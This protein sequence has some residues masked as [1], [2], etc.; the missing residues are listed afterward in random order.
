MNKIVG[1]CVSPESLDRSVDIFDVGFIVKEIQVGKYV[2]TIW[3]FDEVLSCVVNDKYSLAFPVNGSLLDRNVLISVVGGEVVIENDWLGSIPIFYNTTKKIA[4]SL[5][6]HCVADSTVSQEGLELYCEHGYAAYG[7]TIYKEVRFLRYFSRITFA[8]T[9]LVVKKKPDPIRELDY[10]SVE[11]G[12]DTVVDTL[13]AYVRRVEVGLGG[14]IILPTSGG[15]DSRLL[16]YLVEDRSKIRSFTYGNS[17]DQNKSTEVVYAKRISEIFQTKWKRIELTSFHEYIGKWFS[18]FGVSTHLH[19]MY[20]IEFYKKILLDE[21]LAGSSLL[22]GIVGDAWAGSISVPVIEKPSD[23]S[24]L[25][26]THGMSF[27]IKHLNDLVCGEDRDSF[28]NENKDLLTDSRHRIIFLIR[29]KIILLSYL[30]Q[31]PEY[32]GVPAWTPFLNLECVFKMLC[33]P[34]QERKNRKWQTELFRQTGL[35]L[36]SEKLKSIRS[37]RLDAEVLKGARLEP[38]NVEVLAEYVSAHRVDEINKILTIYTSG[39]LS[40]QKVFL[41]AVS[42]CLTISKVGGLLRKLGFKNR[43]LL[44]LYQYYVLKAVEKGIADAR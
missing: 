3:G 14:N 11:V 6:Q 33:L 16:N 21:G 28:F 15:F 9:G 19:G 2:L 4:S 31:V 7:A 35:D 24:K 44:A 27:P 8:K 42:Y 29:N 5:I 32:M 10:D 22:S 18:C 40:M 30:M 36:E 43:V 25:G 17:S 20:Q 12:S 34:D 1:F 37:N 23:L 39:K 41:N 13:T 38:L 26:Y